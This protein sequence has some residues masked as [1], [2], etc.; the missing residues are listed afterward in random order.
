MG[1]HSLH[2]LKL[3]FECTQ[4][5]CI[6]M[7]HCTI[8]SSFFFLQLQVSEHMESESN[9]ATAGQSSAS[10]VERRLATV[11]SEVRHTKSS[12]LFWIVASQCTVLG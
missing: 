12:F 3:L 1:K 7:L 10:D 6:Y 8:L 4:S 11:E 2:V 5:F 9:P